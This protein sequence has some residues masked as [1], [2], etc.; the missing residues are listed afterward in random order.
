MRSKAIFMALLAL[1]FGA[2]GASV[3]RET[4][5]LAA[6]GWARGSGALGARIGSSVESS[7]VHATTNGAA[8]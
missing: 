3:S 4:A 6:C 2:Q 7:A 1:A 8:F 5:E